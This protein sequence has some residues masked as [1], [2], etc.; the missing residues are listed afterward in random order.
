MAK[1]DETMY[2]IRVTEGEMPPY[3]QAASGTY[4]TPKLY[5]IG[6]AKAVA[7][8]MQSDYWKRKIEIVPVT[9]VL[10]EGEVV[11]DNR[12]TQ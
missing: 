10:G 9:F 11:A 8:T 6:N 5:R 7:K 4:A 2:V 12:E 3:F 1:L